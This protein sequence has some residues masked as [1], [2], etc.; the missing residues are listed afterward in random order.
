[1]DTRS[2]ITARKLFLIRALQLRLGYGWM[3][4]VQAAGIQL[5]MRD[6][7]DSSRWDPSMTKL[8]EF[9]RAYGFVDPLD[10]L[11]PCQDYAER[12]RQVLAEDLAASKHFQD[13]AVH[14]TAGG[15]ENVEADPS[16]ALPLA[17]LLAERFGLPALPAAAPHLSKD[18][19]PDSKDHGNRKLTPVDRAVARL[20][21]AGFVR[22]RAQAVENLTRVLERADKGIKPRKPGRPKKRKPKAK[23][24][25]SNLSKPLRRLPKQ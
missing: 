24:I 25:P 15:L 9:A 19:R 10:D 12:I 5:R 14:P 13:P 7:C 4:A 11:G 3:R 20:A 21:A 2:F 6:F 17:G 8:E 16:N 23:A 1:M 22:D 18:P